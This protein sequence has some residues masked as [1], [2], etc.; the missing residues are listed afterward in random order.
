VLG[1]LIPALP[2]LEL[3]WRAGFLRR[4]RTHF[5]WAH[6]AAHAVETL[7]AL[8]DEPSG[9]FLRELVIL[10]APKDN[11]SP[12]ASAI[13]AR[14]LPAL[15]A[16]VID[17][18]GPDRRERP[19]TRLEL[20]PIYTAMPNLR[21]LSI[22]VGH[23]TLGEI[24]LPHL[25]RFELA[26]GSL[27]GRAAKAIASARW[28]S[29][30]SLAIQVGAWRRGGTAKL[31]DL[32]PIFHGARLPRLTHLAVTNHELS[33]DLVEMLG[34]S[35]LLAQLEVLDLRNATLSDAGAAIL[36][37]HQHAYAHL[38]TIRLDDNILTAAGIALLESTGLPVALGRQ[39]QDPGTPELRVLP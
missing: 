18:S 28:P 10:G 35:Q 24:T 5:T 38:R 32:R 14:Y 19:N 36:Y 31:K 30:R 9:R 23:L 8:L 21:A 11:Y 13:G 16:L 29:L 3:T 20:E 26:T 27:V 15:R 6:A 39:R 34:T 37:R 17:E 1:K 33:D 22:R 12:L 25:E 2:H 4:V 7:A